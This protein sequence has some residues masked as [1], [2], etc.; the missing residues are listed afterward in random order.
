M[1]VQGKPIQTHIKN[2]RLIDQR[3]KQ[4]VEGALKIFT[5]KGF[6][7]T[8][9]REI[10]E[11]AGVTMGTLY[12]YVRS[13]E[14]ILYIVYDYMTTILTDSL[15]TIL[16]HSNDPKMNVREALKHNMKLL[17]DHQDLVLFL[18]RESGSFDREAVRTVLAQET[19]YIEVFEELLQQHF[20]GKR[21]DETRLKLAA[22]ILSYLN[23]ILVLRRWSLK[24]R[25]KSIDDV[26][27]GILDF[28]GKAIQTIEDPG[29]K[30]KKRPGVKK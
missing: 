10:A 17:Y 14:D 9:V 19:R 24:R 30:T 22:D 2:D 7:Q 11:A 1:K 25:Y 18:Y 20:A 3:R 28:V 26:M 21:I 16:K 15:R 8:T 12:N 6:H 4:I 29:R 5:V 23:T 13:K 27:E